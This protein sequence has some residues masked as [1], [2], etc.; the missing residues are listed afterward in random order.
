M[1]QVALGFLGLDLPAD[2]RDLLYDITNWKLTPSH[3][4]QTILDAA[5]LLPVVGSI[6]YSDEAADAVK[7]VVKHGD[8]VASIL[9]TLPNVDK[10][11][12]DPKK[13]T[14]YA[15]NLEH[16]LGRNKA[17]VFKSVLGYEEAEANHLILQIQE[18]LHTC[19]AIPG[20]IDEYGKRYMV[21]IPITGMN[22][23]TAIVRTG[24]I[25]KLGIDIPE[26]VTIYVK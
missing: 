6:K 17:K 16:P 21:D 25:L 14:G 2:M 22:G 8:D 20:K 10:A 23:N 26:L 7:G 11:K 12:I 5:A 24:W 3:A 18:K 1:G 15:L 4:L 13:L 9:E 19:K